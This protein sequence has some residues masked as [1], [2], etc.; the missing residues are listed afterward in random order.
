MAARRQHV[1]FRARE[2][3]APLLTGLLWLAAV[4]L[5]RSLWALL[6]REE[7]AQ[8]RSESN[9]IAAWALVFASPI[10][11]P[12]VLAWI[13]CITR[14]WR[15]GIIGLPPALVFLAFYGSALFAFLTESV[16]A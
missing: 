2:E 7:T 9:E 11:V 1:G 15:W 16:F 4:L 5:R 10:L 12:L 14:S 13:V 3:W 8:V 6:V